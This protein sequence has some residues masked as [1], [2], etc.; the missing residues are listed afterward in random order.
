MSVATILRQGLATLFNS[1][2]VNILAEATKTEKPFNLL[3]EHFSFTADEIAQAFQQ[4]YG[5]ALAA[6]STGLVSPENQQGFWKSLFQSQAT[7]DITRRLEREYLQPFARQQNLTIPELQDF[8]LLAL[9]QCQIIAKLPIFQ[10]DKIP[11]SEAELAS[12]VT[13]SG[14]TS[15]TEL[16]LEE[17]QTHL[18]DN[19][20]AVGQH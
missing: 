2:V 1:A 12:F 14:A 5:Y 16:I 4:S 9:A 10:A 19:A 8:C 18:D 13:D 11:F 7:S 6:I 17:I 3:K 20:R 15:I